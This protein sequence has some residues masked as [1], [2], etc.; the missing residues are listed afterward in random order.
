M[1][2]AFQIK[3]VPYLHHAGEALLARLY[4][5]EGRGPFPG[6]VEVHGGAW[7]SNDRLSNTAI[8]TKLA[9]SGV[10]VMAIDFRLAPVKYPAALEDINY[11]VRWFKAH[12]GE[13]SIRPDRI[14]GLGTS[15]GG[16]QLMLSALRPRDPRYSI[17]PGGADDASLA[18]I[19]LCWPIVDPLARYRMAIATGLER[20][21]AAHD[22]WWPDEAAM[23][24]ANPQL[25]LERGEAG[26]LPP[27]LVIQ[28]TNDANVTPDMADRFA[29]AYRK[30]GGMLDLKKFD[31]EPHAFIGQDPAAPAAVAALDAIAGFVRA[32]A[33]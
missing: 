10:V 5:P 28:G 31:G 9:E 13:L 14:G 11:A 7:G 24:D 1:P 32:H 2:V 20:L 16:H 17:V 27:V 26:T 15:S 4:I 29:A 19:A 6:V 3:D 30:A 22:L 18:F 8:H 12:A 25:I 33:S 23:A 21:Q